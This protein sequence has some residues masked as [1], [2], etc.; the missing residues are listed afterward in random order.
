MAVRVLGLTSGTTPEDH[1]L[2]LAAFSSPLGGVLDRASGVV[3]HPGACELRAAGRLEA[4][5]T[6]FT[7]LVDGTS[8]PLQGAYPVVSDAE[9][10]IAFDPGEPSVE[11]VDQ[12]IVR[13]R[14]GAYDGSGAQ[15]GSVDYLKGQASGAAAPLPSGALALWQVRVP[16]GALAIDFAAS[17]VRAHGYTTGPGTPLPVESQAA[18]DGLP[19]HPGLAVIR[20]D[21]GEWEQYWQGAWRRLGWS[22]D[23]EWTPITEFNPVWS[24]S[25]N[26]KVRRIGP[27]IELTGYTAPASRAPASGS[28]PAD[29]LVL[30]LPSEFTP[31]TP[32]RWPAPF[33]YTSSGRIN[34]SVEPSGWLQIAT[35]YAD[36][37]VG[38]TIT[39]DTFWLAG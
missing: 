4:R 12:V 10:S 20:L 7:A 5:I 27:Y 21:T 29:P 23:T 35:D 22:T 39:L 15:Y 30:R 38:S 1:R 28:R 33:S 34:L 25:W 17:S 18:R 3:F 31:Q 26:P 19:A 32:V 9:A 2:G 36:V 24:S 16:R 13:V 8:H 37:P 6:P 14:D 11:R